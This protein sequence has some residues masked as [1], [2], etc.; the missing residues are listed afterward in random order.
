SCVLIAGGTD[1]GLEFDAWAKVVVKRIEPENIIL[2]SG[3]ATKKMLDAIGFLAQRVTV[4]DTLLDCVKA[5]LMRG[6]QFKSSIVLFSP[7]AKSFEKFRNEMDRGTQ[8]NKI[9]KRE[10]AK[11]MKH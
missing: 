2:L 9:V 5:G 10:I 6:I 7:A 11:W 3:S 4:R 8:F 1:R